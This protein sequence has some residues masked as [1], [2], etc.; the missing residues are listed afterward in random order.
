MIRGRMKFR[1]MFISTVMALALASA[2]GGSQS[3]ASATSRA[4][5]TLRL[6]YFPN[7]TH[8]TALVGLSKG[9]YAKD[10]GPKVTLKT[11]TFN[12]GPAAGEALF[13]GAIDASYVGPNPA[14]NAF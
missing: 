14:I 6:G 4:P 2:C 11:S 7:I 12:A 13:S 9:I 5:V 10:L 8:A 1:T 3:S